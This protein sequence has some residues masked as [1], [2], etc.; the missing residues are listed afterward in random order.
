MVDLNIT[1]TENRVTPIATFINTPLY[2]TKTKNSQN[3][4]PP[5]L[6]H[7]WNRWT[8]RGNWAFWGE[9]FKTTGIQV[10]K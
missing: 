4:R 9:P 3:F 7:L 6:R 8:I 2:N 5:R 1:S 10:Q